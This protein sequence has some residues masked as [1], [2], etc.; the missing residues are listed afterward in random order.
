MSMNKDKVKEKELFDFDAPF[1]SLV[2]KGAN[3]KVFFL[4]KNYGGINMEL[5]NELLLKLEKILKESTFSEDIEKS[6]EEEIQKAGVSPEVTTAIKSALK[7]LEAHKK[8]IGEDVI[9]KLTK[10]AGFGPEMPKKEEPKEPTKDDMKSS[11]LKSYG[12]EKKEKIEK[13]F[14]DLEKKE[15]NKELQNSPEYVAIMKENEEM[16]SKLEKAEKI[17]IEKEYEEK[18]NSYENLNIDKKELKE[19]LMKASEINSESSS[20]S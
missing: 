13:F 19:L 1:I 6:L 4:T 7:L 5:N 16:K 12:E 20:A 11:M 15:I 18:A 14:E 17:N 3:K 2:P 10:I 9:K 8:E